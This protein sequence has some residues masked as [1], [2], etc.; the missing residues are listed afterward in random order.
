MMAIKQVT[1]DRVIMDAN[2]RRKEAEALAELLDEDELLLALA[3]IQELQ[4]NTGCSSSID[5]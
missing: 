5:S 1:K 2:K 3:F 4:A